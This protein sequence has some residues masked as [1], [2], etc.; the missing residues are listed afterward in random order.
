[1]RKVRSDD[2]DFLLNL[3]QLL[4]FLPASVLE[5]VADSSGDRIA[6]EQLLAG[7]IGNIPANTY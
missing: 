4:D 5:S 3:P 7:A 2:L 6:I 1:M